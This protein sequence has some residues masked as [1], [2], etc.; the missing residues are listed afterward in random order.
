MSEPKRTTLQISNADLTFFIEVEQ[1]A[2]P[3]L[4]N[5]RAFQH[6]RGGAP[7]AEQSGCQGWGEVVEVVS[8]LAAEL[9]TKL[10]T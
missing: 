1:D 10:L 8:G 6:A 4:Y 9:A 2:A 5:V 3:M 7:L